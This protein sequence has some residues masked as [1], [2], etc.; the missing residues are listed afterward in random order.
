MTKKNILVVAAHPDDEILGA[1]GTLIKHAV[2]GDD[3]YCLILGEGIMS[4]AN[5]DKQKLEELRT[6][7]LDAGRVVGFKKIF[8]SNFPDNVFDTV[9]LLNIVKD[10]EKYFDELKP[11]IVYTHHGNDLNIDHQLTFQAVLTASRPCNE[12]CPREIYTFETL[13]STEWQEKNKG[14]FSPNTYIDI[15]STIEKKIA[16]M[17][18]YSSELREY[19]Y[20]RSVE[21]IRIL[22]Q[23]RGLESGLFFAEAFRLIRK[24]DK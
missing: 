3:V 24:I 6:Q 9:P 23:L 8:L 10:V 19:P 13:S 15:K 17:K 7:A 11:D 12:N 14:Q 22:S 1:G 21:G 20:P 5:P 2:S 18:K 16:A 4:R